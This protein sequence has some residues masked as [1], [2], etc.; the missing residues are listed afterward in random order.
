MEFACYILRKIGPL[1][2]ET[3]KRHK[4][5]LL[6]GA[7]QTGKTT[8]IDRLNPDFSLSF[9]QPD[10]RLLYEQ[11]P[12]RL[13]GEV[14]ALAETIAKKPLVCIDEVQKVPEILDV[15][16]DLIDRKIANFVLSGSS[17]R[18]LRSGTKVNLLP[19]RVVLLHLDPL[20]YSEL[21]S[22]QPN[23]TLCALVRA[24]R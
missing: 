7:R 9:I 13:A 12:S 2:Q 17:A 3:L 16:Q 21:S 8:L 14:T 1:L 23:I 19:G 15:V 10:T 11:N 22:L 5:I 18:K 20:T 24:T 4:S 6:L